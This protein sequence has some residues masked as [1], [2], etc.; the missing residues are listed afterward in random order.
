MKSLGNKFLPRSDGLAVGNGAIDE[1]IALLANLIP[2]PQNL[3]PF[4]RKDA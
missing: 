3:I 4:M 2:N 1:R